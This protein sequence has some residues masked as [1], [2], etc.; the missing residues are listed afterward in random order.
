MA[1]HPYSD[2]IELSQ[3]LSE[4]EELIATPDLAIASNAPKPTPLSAVELTSE[5]DQ[6]MDQATADAQARLGEQFPH[7]HTQILTDSTDLLCGLFAIRESIQNQ[8]P[9]IPVPDIQDL[10]LIANIPKLNIRSCN[11]YTDSELARIFQQWATIHGYEDFVLAYIVKEGFPYLSG[12]GP[13]D[14]TTARVLWI[15]NDNAQVLFAGSEIAV[16]NHWS[17][18]QP[19]P[20]PASSTSPTN[21]ALAAASEPSPIAPFNTDTGTEGKPQSQSQ[22]EDALSEPLPEYQ[23]HAQSKQPQQEQDP[24]D[25][26][27][28]INEPRRSKRNVKPTAKAEHQQQQ[29]QKQPARAPP[30][31]RLLCPMTDCNGSADTLIELNR[32][33]IES[34]KGVKRFK[35]AQVTKV[36]FLRWLNGGKSAS[37]CE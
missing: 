27:A 5:K 19:N 25:L 33:R 16:I 18:V 20:A 28:P 2:N 14:D 35:S 17:G 26:S 31:F 8:Y 37:S 6:Q 32:H 22:V 13:A 36:D 1:A 34:H 4:Q 29:P 7:G 11:T 9:E 23:P 3:D 12:Y 15:H 21:V 30:P 10:E 24:S